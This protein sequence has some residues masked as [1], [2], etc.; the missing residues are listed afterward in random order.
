MGC[1]YG[2]WYSK[3]GDTSKAD[4]W[5]FHNEALELYQLLLHDPKQYF[6]ALFYNNY[7]NLSGVL[8]PKGYW[9]DLKDNLMLLLV[10]LMDVI[11]G[12]RYYINVI[13]YSFITFFAFILWYQLIKTILAKQPGTVTTLIIFFTPSC[14]F[15]T[16]GIH[17]DGMVFLFI[18][19]TFW[20]CYQ[21]LYN[22][23]KNHWPALFAIISF[24]CLALF[25]NYIALALL[26]ALSVLFILK[27]YRFKPFWVFSTSVLL[28]IAIVFIVPLFFPSINLPE[29]LI[30]RKIDFEK[31]EGSS[32]LTSLP[33]SPTFTSFVKNLPQ[34]AE[35]SF[36]MPYLPKS[37]TLMEKIAAIEILFVIAAIIFSL[38]VKRNNSFQHVNSFQYA[39]IFFVLVTLLLIGY[40]VPFSG[41]IVRYRAI[42]L[43][44]LLSAVSIKINLEKK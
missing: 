2:F 18:T 1:Y 30:Q 3:T 22:I 32:R 39:V 34:A 5:R 21:L 41:A 36:L 25:R 17:R 44:L 29:K 40:I 11:S 20:F 43:M 7:N 4:T 24:I 16:S 10:S 14:L 31:L 23:K 8:A 12:G 15:W 19:L 26:P 37:K 28:C 27:K 42:P 9:N 35:R 33:L 38:F 13:I 6:N